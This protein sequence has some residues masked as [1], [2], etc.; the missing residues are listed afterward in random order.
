MAVCQDCQCQAHL[1]ELAA[2]EAR[3]LSCLG[4]KVV[5]GKPAAVTQSL[6]QFVGGPIQHPESRLQKMEYAVHL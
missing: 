3:P 6:V 4:A 1:E 2:T 5:H